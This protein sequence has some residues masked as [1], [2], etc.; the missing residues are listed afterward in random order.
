MDGAASLA[1]KEIGRVLPANYRKVPF[2]RA[3]KS[4]NEAPTARYFSDLSGGS[5]ELCA[6]HLHT[7]IQRALRR[8]HRWGDY[9]GDMMTAEICRAK[10][11]GQ[12][13]HIGT[14]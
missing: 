5:P 12:S 9:E 10:G 4:L 2:F 13:V 11:Q 1:N 14:D 8:L 6:D 7:A 3:A